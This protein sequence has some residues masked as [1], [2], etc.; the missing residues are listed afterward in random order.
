MDKD[1]R[2]PEIRRKWIIRDPFEDLYRIPWSKIEGVN[3][4]KRGCVQ[5]G[6][7]FFLRFKVMKVC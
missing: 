1:L 6:D 3:I 5:T 2:I 7:F 4:E